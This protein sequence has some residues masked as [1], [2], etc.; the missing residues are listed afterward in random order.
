M[1]MRAKQ[2]SVFAENRPGRL[3]SLLAALADAA[4]DIRALSI[5]ETTDFGIVRLI[6]SDT[7]KGRQALRD[8][9]FTNSVN[10]VLAVQVPDRPGGFLKTVVEPLTAAGVNIEYVYAFA[11]N[12][13]QHA[14]VVLKVSDHDR[15]EGLIET[16]TGQ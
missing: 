9:D 5:A 6:L 8:A 12:P 13:S 4:V 7:E 1:T 3:S 11:D 15:A 10:D 14:L 16:S 2:V